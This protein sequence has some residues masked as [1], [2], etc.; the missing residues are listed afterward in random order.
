MI[1][2][3]E[4]IRNLVTLA[5]SEDP[6]FAQEFIADFTSYFSSMGKLARLMVE[7]LSESLG[8]SPDTFTKL[9][10]PNALSNARVNHYP[11]CP[12]PTKVVGIPAHADPQMLSINYQDE[13]GG[14]QLLKEDKWVGIRP[15]DSTFVCNV[16]DTFQALTNG[17]LHSPIHRVAVNATKS[18]YATIYFYGIDNTVP[19]TVPPQLVTPERPLK[20]RPF[21]VNEYRQHLVSREL[22]ADGVKFLEVR[23]EEEAEPPH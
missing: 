21:I 19:L 10:T 5:W 9:E 17:I 1:V 6:E 15:D 23:T 8:L 16:G 13:V 2:H 18:R 12:D 20:Y 22:P 11:P 4:A 7:C 3:E 14:L